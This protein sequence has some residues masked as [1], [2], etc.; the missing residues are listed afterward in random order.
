MDETLIPTQ[1]A[2]VGYSILV[3]LTRGGREVKERTNE[4][5]M[6][7]IID[8]YTVRINVWFIEENIH[9]WNELNKRENWNSA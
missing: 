9:I 7:R 8:T 1:D 2:L 6:K 4:K 3:N 5:T